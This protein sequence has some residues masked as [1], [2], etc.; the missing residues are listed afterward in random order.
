MTRRRA[1]IARLLLAI[2]AIVSIELGILKIFT[3]YNSIWRSGPL[4]YIIAIGAIVGGLFVY[5]SK[6]SKVILAINY[7]FLAFEAYKAIIDYRDFRD[8]LLCVIAII[9]LII[10]IIRY[11]LKHKDP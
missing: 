6:G 4:D 5:A 11:S 3:H 2:T 8:V 7:V 10:P 1:K 9:C